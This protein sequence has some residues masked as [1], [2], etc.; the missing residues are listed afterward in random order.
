MAGIVNGY[1]KDNQ[2][3]LFMSDCKKT[4]RDPD[5]CGKIQ[6]NS[7]LYFVAAWKNTSRRTGEDFYKGLLHLDGQRGKNLG[8]MTLYKNKFYDSDTNKLPMIYGRLQLEGKS[9]KVHLWKKTRNERKPFYSGVI[10]S[11]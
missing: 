7:V 5:L 10:R 4:Q 3:R 1:L 9:Y 6:M 2:V 8:S 11:I